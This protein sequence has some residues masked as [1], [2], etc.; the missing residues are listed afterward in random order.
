MSSGPAVLAI[1]SEPPSGPSSEQLRRLAEM[2]ESWSR[3]STFCKA[4]TAQI[5][6]QKS[7]TASSTSPRS[8]GPSG[9]GER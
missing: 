4:T 8:R 9:K 7:L 5:Q 1:A 2:R 6:L 3:F